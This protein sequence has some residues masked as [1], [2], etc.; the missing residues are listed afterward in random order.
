M[1]D[2]LR[3]GQM[4]PS[5]ARGHALGG[6]KKA[7]ERPC[8][9]CSQG[10]LPSRKRNGV[11]VN[12]EWCWQWTL[13]PVHSGFKWKSE[14]GRNL[15]VQSMSWANKCVA[16]TGTLEGQGLQNHKGNQGRETG[17]ARLPGLQ[18]PWGPK[19]EMCCRAGVGA[20][21]ELTGLR[22]GPSVRGSRMSQRWREGKRGSLRKIQHSLPTKFKSPGGEQAS[23]INRECGGLAL[24][25]PH[26]R[27]QNVFFFLDGQTCLHVHRAITVE[28]W[29]A[30][31][32]TLLPGCFL[33][34]Y[35]HPATR[36]C[37]THASIW[38]ACLFPVL[39]TRPQTAERVLYSPSP[40]CSENGRQ[41][42]QSQLHKSAMTL[43][44]HQENA[45]WI[46]ALTHH[47][48]D[49]QL[50]EAKR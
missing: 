34:L 21:E 6:K 26:Q 46:L 29:Q 43:L 1:E 9:S 17:L 47:Q 30:L 33:C 16:D 11:P 38:F 14:Q 8:S 20:R 2:E 36:H 7:A 27:S 13:R 39:T 31:S 5:P 50:R 4:I 3:Q 35:T 12:R 24:Q 22:G 23:T 40:P 42:T 48:W 25:G 41:R 28:T 15:E 49:P 19:Q 32:I 44:L 18:G 37:F 10:W 45:W